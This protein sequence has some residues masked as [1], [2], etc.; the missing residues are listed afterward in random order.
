TS[1]FDLT[2]QITLNMIYDIPFGTGKRFSSGNRA[3]D[4]VLGNWQVNTIFVARSGQVYNVYVGSDVANTG[5]VGWTQYERANLVGDAGKV[6]DKSWNHY[7]NT[8]AF[9]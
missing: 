9:H 5:N 2:Q 3:V 8:A 1:G 4:Y 6:P 7:I